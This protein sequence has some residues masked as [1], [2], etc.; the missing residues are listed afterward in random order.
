MSSLDEYI[1]SGPSNR[2]L[3]S[4]PVLDARLNLIDELAWEL[5]SV[6]G[7]HWMMIDSAEQGR[8]VA[9]AECALE[10]SERHRERPRAAI[11]EVEAA[12]EKIDV[13]GK[14]LLRQL[15]DA[16]DDAELDDD[17]DDFDGEESA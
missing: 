17:D 15:D 14:W 10:F 13:Y 6:G 16:L 3:S 12:L 2:H 8:Y 9:L 4:D 1:R 5:A 7:S 11:T